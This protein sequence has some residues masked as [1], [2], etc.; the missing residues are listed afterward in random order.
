M[1]G[2]ASY[3]YSFNGGDPVTVKAGDDDQPVS[4]P[5]SPTDSGSNYLYVYATTKDGI[6]L[7]GSWY[8]FT[9]N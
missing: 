9:V 6:Q 4:I 7:A 2:V 5:W 3:T 8:W 1:K